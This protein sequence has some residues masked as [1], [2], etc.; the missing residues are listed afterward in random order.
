MVTP[1]F[2][3][4]FRPDE[5]RRTRSLA[6]RAERLYAE[7][8][9]PADARGRRAH[10][11]V[12]PYGGGKSPRRESVKS[13]VWGTWITGE[14]SVKIEL[15]R[16][17]PYVGF[18]LP[19]RAADALGA[20]AG[21]TAPQEV[22]RW[23]VRSMKEGSTGGFMQS[24]FDSQ[25]KLSLREYVRARYGD[26]ALGRLWRSNLPFDQ[27]APAVLG[28]DAPELEAQWRRDLL[29]LGPNPDPA[30]GPGTLAAAVGWGALILLAGMGLARR[31]EVA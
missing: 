18:G 8:G 5:A 24:F 22:H 2:V 30:P 9:Y 13:A 6:R 21:W 1:H 20:R 11:W 12:V 31:R 7:S 28:V 19:G 14:G 10:Y 27:A 17:L 26:A 25:G 15:A 16:S 23:A 4:H 3:L 29:A